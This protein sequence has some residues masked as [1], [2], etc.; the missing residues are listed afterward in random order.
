M[1]I[2]FTL[3]ISLLSI[4]AFSQGYLHVDGK[5]IVDGN[6]ENFIIRSIGTGNWM[7]Q[8]GY[9]MQTS[10]VAGTQHEFRAKLIETIG[11]E[12]TNQFYETWLANHF[13]KRDVDSMAAW[14]FNSVRVAMHYKWFTPP[15]EDE[16]VQGEITWLNKGFEMIDDLLDWCGANEM[17]LILDLHGAPGGQGKD[18]A[19]SDYDETKPSLWESDLNKEKTVAL[20][21]KLA[22]RYANEPWIGGY[23]LI[24]EINWTFP[25]GNNSQIRTLYGQITNAIRE[26]DNNHIIYIEGN[27][28]AND[29]SGL[30]PAWD[31]NMVYSF[32]KYWSYNNTSSI[33]WM[34]DLRESENRPIWLGETGE[35][36]NTWF[37]NLVKLCEDNNIGWSWWPVKKSGINNVMYVET[38]DDY[39]QLIEVWKGNGTMTADE[40][41]DA[42]MGYAEAHKIENC[43]MRY[44]V[45]D[46][47]T[48]QPYTTETKPFKPYSTG[49]NIFVVDYDLGRNDYAYFDFD[50]ANHHLNTNEYTAWNV[51]WA[52]RND[53]VDIQECD[54]NVTI[55]YSIGW[56]SAGEWT[57][58]TINSEAAGA[59]KFEVRTASE[60]DA[61]VYIEVNGKVA[62]KPISIPKTGSWKGWETTIANNRIILPD[63]ECKIRLVI[64]NGSANINYFKFY[65]AQ[66]AENV[67]FEMMTAETH[68]I[69]NKILLNLNKAVTS[70][71]FNVADFQLIIGSSV[72][73][74]ESVTL[75]TNNAQQLIVSTNKV[76]SAGDKV[77]ISYNGNSI[78][79]YT[80]NLTAFTAIEANNK[81]YKFYDIPGQV[82]AENFYKNFGFELEDCNEGGKNVAYASNNDYLE[83]IVNVTDAGVYKMNFRVATEKN[84]G[85]LMVQLKDG[86]KYVNKQLMKFTSTGSW[87]TWQNQSVNVELPAGKH[88]LRLLSHKSEYNLNWISF[89]LI[90]TGVEKKKIDSG[91]KIYPNPATDRIKIGF[92][93]CEKRNIQLF[94]IN[95]KQLLN[96]ESSEKNIELNI[97]TLTEGFYIV[98]I[99][100]AQGNVSKKVMVVR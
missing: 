60:Q 43:Q 10:D 29:F 76:I 46:A 53:G 86:D 94:D 63:G 87:Q 71:D 88:I 97:N 61:T 50:T 15:I 67:D 17:Y 26:V 37:T 48:R 51:G 33:Q 64:D 85:E 32:H 36:S 13:T 7:L 77:R 27:W 28:F 58:Y 39:K 49:Q 54:D 72:A 30:T 62:S 6:G 19:I 99:N 59:Y 56:N 25:E 78:T 98:N 68:T 66:S 42:V 2:T 9:M 100:S 1:R 22:E 69:E 35:N 31:D 95:G 34:L 57:Q 79:A 81:M 14:G 52:Y 82:E 21:R 8:E 11:E 47:L 74:I 90:S 23:D 75:S 70:S 44:D 16:P 18:A 12:R 73:T 3:L 83:Y 4:S 24:N 41:F 40:A 45:I 89:E 20:W 5:K 65:D 96:K 80:Q 92:E 93:E 38:N 91:L 84:D 55:G